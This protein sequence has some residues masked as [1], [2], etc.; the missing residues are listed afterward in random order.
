MEEDIKKLEKYTEKDIPCD[1]CRYCGER[2]NVSKALRN[3]IARYKE[4]EQEKEKYKKLANENLRNEIIFREKEQPED[5]YI[6]QE[7]YIPKSKV[8]EKIEELDKEYFKMLSDGTLSLETKNIN[9]HREDAM[10]TVLEELLEGD[11]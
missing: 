2:P 10:K 5:V 8:Q 3:L 4:L 7:M 9:A 11:K 6:K 1:S